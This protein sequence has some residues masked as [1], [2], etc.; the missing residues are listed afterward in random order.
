MQLPGSSIARAVA[1]AIFLVAGAS[2][3]QTQ[4]LAQRQHRVVSLKEALQLAAQKG[5]DVA[6]ARAQA[7]VVGVGVER[8]YTAW[9][10]DL[11]ATGTF[12]HTS[13]PQIFDPAK[14]GLAGPPLE[15]VGANSRFGTVQLSQPLF[16]PQGLFLPGVAKNAADAASKGADEAREQVLLGVARAYLGLQSLEGLLDAARDAER[17]ALRREEDA[18][19]R[20]AA[21]T[22]VEIAL[23][24]A[25]TDTASARVQIATLEGQQASL[26]PTLEAFTGEAIAPQPLSSAP[27]LIP[28]PA[29]E[30]TQPW[31]RT[32]G[33]QSA[34][35]QV[36]AAQ[37]SVKYDDYLWLPSIAGVAKGNYNSNA[38]F[39]G[40]NTSYDLILNVSIPLYDRGIRYTQLHEDQARLRQGV[41]NLA[42]T[43]ARARAAWEGARANL[44]SSE[45]T[46]TQA[47]SQAMLAARAQEQVEASYRAGVAT[48]LDLTDADNKKFAAASGAAQARATVEV[49]RAEVAA[50]EGRLFDDLGR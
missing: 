24:R 33:V 39:A 26:L 6:A 38:G 15:I 29:E 43:R 16:T 37:G 10:P 2:A 42:A 35:A 1:V 8:A 3:A 31:E 11:V 17:V 7:D 12:D 34:I 41:A 5:P 23:L 50:A 18:K 13:A 28:G 9:K 44:M 4:P 45:V 32:Y 25:Q 48:S 27:S 20:I 40:T 36:R 14:L 21:G 30:A 22:D 19:S 46:L 47:N 49:R